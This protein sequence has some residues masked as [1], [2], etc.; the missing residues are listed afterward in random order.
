MFIIHT[1]IHRGQ[2]LSPIRDVTD[3]LLIYRK[4]KINAD[5]DDM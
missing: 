4:M 1:Y 3:G 5:N 2:I